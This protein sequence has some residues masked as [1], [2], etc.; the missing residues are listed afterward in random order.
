MIGFGRKAAAFAVTLAFSAAVVTGPAT[1]QEL[2]I[3]IK[4]EPSALDPQFHTLNPNIQVADHFFDALVAQDE[5]LKPKP[6]L[7]LSWKTVDE[8][9]WEFKLRPNVKFHDGGDFTAADVVYTYERIPKVPNSPGPYTIYTRSMKSFEIVDPLTLRIHTNGPAPLLLLDLAAL[10]ILSKKAMSAG[11]APEGRTTAELNAG[12]G[13]VG[14][15]PFKFVEW[16]RGSRIVG[17]RND[18][19]WGPKPAWQ[20]IILRVL[21]N[22]TTRVAALLSGDVDMIE[23]PP[24]T[25]LAKLKSDPKITLEK[26][27]SNRVI[28]IALDQHGEPPIAIPDTNGKNPL[29]DPRVREALSIAIDRK[30]IANKIM[31]GV[32]IPAGDL[33]PYPMGGTRKD[34][35]VDPY[36]PAKAKKLLEEA[37]YPKGFS[38]TLGAPNGRYINDL[39]IA[40]AVAAMWTRIGVKTDVD[41]NAPPVFFKNRDSFKYSAYMAGWGASTGE[42]SN[43]LKSL[44]ATPDRSKGM[45]TTNSGKHSNKEMDAKL[46]QALVTIDDAKREALLADAS[47]ILMAEHGIIPI[48]F[49]VSVWA[50]R[51]GLTY[52]GRA[53]QNTFGFDVKPAK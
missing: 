48:H 14:T 9:T 49:E 47:K 46:E 3:G 50:L 34:T 37:G 43:A 45:G 5:N 31:E 16:Q 7:A 19:Y 42:L 12:T 17:E 4:T 33:L 36:D 22:N 2:K 51:K 28:Y 27:I 52:T 26:A 39:K 21:S 32:A 25:D 20:K 38:I 23:D 10:P 18:N 53:D 6:A 29:M 40:Q 30:G 15:G 24:T 41:A 13:L 11:S 44:A 1:A 35:P 8:T